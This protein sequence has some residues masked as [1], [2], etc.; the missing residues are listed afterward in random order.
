MISSRSSRL[1]LWGWAFL[2][3]AH[4]VISDDL[5]ISSHGLFSIAMLNTLWSTVTVCE[6]ENGPFIVDLPIKNGDEFHS[7][8]NVYQRVTRG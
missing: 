4:G 7:Y 5:R 8:V 2:S 6:L 1:P 3:M